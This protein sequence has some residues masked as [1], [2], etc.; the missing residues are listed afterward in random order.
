[1]KKI[2]KMLIFI[3]RKNHE[4]KPWKCWLSFDEKNC[5]NVNFELTNKKKKLD[6][7]VKMFTLIWR[8]KS[9]KC[10]LL[11]DEKKM[12]FLWKE[13]WKNREN[14]D[15]DLTKKVYFSFMKKNHEKIVKML[16]LNWRK[17][18]WKCW[19]WFNEIRFA[20]DSTIQ[21]HLADL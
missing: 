20:P 5:E 17:K 12:Y 19:L 7:N 10:W 8:K 1:M 18:S 21:A 2:V 3:W 4:K 11:I 14:V 16:T 9:W 6:K 13:S 15:F